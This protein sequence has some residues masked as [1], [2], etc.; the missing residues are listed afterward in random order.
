M[1]EVAGK[2]RAWQF[3]PVASPSL[4]VTKTLRSA[5]LEGCALCQETLSSSELAA[6]TRDGD[7]E[8]EWE[9]WGQWPVCYTLHSR[10]LLWT[11][12]APSKCRHHRPSRGAVFCGSPL[13]SPQLCILF[14][15]PRW[16][17]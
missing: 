12:S 5:A 10:T 6:K 14:S 4:L 8:G 2:L 11:L 17:H 3:V 9:A 16:A 1:F 13:P 7:F 15:A